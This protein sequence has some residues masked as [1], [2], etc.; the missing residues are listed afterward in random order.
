[1]SAGRNDSS[2]SAAAG[3]ILAPPAP[4]RDKLLQRWGGDRELVPMR[5]F[6]LTLCYSAAKDLGEA[7][8]TRLQIRRRES[9]PVSN[10]WMREVV[11]SSFC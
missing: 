1:V 2:P 10:S 6:G 3:S 7:S 4:F 9:R 5:Q 11:Q 8:L